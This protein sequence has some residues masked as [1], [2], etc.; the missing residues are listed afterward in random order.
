MSEDL[1]RLFAAWMAG[2]LDDAQSPVLAWSPGGRS[3][4]VQATRS[5]MRAGASMP[6][7]LMTAAG[8]L[9]MAAPACSL[10][11]AMPRWRSLPLVPSPR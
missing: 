4:K 5:V 10:R 1:D 3:A 8:S 6:A 7:R 11:V 9:R 2:P